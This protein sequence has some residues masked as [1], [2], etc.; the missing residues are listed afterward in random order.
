MP[1]HLWSGFLIQPVTEGSAPH[2]W[3]VSLTRPSAQKP[4]RN[5]SHQCSESHVDST[6]PRHF[7][8][9]FSKAQKSKRLTSQIPAPARSGPNEDH[10]PGTLSRFPMSVAGIQVHGPSSVAFSGIMRSCMRIKVAR[11][12]V[13]CWRLQA[14]TSPAEPPIPK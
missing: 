5:C 1:S 12:Q 6:A 2:L 11:S 8:H 3:A 4:A 9:F 13:G 7:R 10:E 14:A